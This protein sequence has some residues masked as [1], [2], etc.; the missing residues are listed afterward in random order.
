M[1]NSTTLST[2]T[3]PSTNEDLTPTQWAHNSI[4]NLQ[5]DLAKYV[6]IFKGVLTYYTSGPDQ[7]SWK[8]VP[9]ATISALRTM[10]PISTKATLKHYREYTN[11]LSVTKCS[12]VSSIKTVIPDEFRAF[13]HSLVRSRLVPELGEE[14][15]DTQNDWK[16]SGPLEAEWLI[17]QKIEL[18]SNQP[19]LLYFHG[20]GFYEGAF[21]TYREPIGKLVTQAGIL[22]LGLS[23]RLA[24]EFTFPCQLEDALATILYLTS[25]TN[26]GFGSNLNK[27]IVAGDSSGGHLTSILFH[28][29]RDAGLGKLAGGLLWSPLLDATHSQPS[30]R[31][32]E[33]S[34]FLEAFNYISPG[35]DRLTVDNNPCFKLTYQGSSDEIRARMNRDGHYLCKIEHINHPLMSPLCDTNFSDLPTMLIQTGNGE[36]LRDEA[37]LYAKKIYQSLTPENSDQIKLQL[38]DEMPHA[39]MVIPGFTKDLTCLN[40]ALKFINK[41][42][43]LDNQPESKSSLRQFECYLVNTKGEIN[44]FDP[45]FRAAEVPTWTQANP[46]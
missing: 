23:Y 4:A 45:E 26:S 28:F 42:L 2:V 36:L 18:N 46:K 39:F 7:P 37:Y 31:E 19:I 34:D 13:A 5:W 41:C 6:G 32:L 35:E 10:G 43:G 33:H 12:T 24:P 1:T 40:E 17:P 9:Q 11:K 27:I 15:F 8:L 14:I 44:N 22:G 30:T 29:M 25:D 38:F 16:N 20:G 3:M 21:S